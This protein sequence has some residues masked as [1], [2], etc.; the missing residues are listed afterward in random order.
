MSWMYGGVQCEGVTLREVGRYELGSNGGLYRTSRGT[1][2][3]ILS[4]CLD[5]PQNLAAPVM[6]PPIVCVG[7]GPHSTPE[8]V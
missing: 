1:R 3:R 4:L 5:D 6:V 2:W 8:A 7:V